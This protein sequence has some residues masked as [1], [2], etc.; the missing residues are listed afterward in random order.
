MNRSDWLN[1]VFP[2]IKRQPFYFP[3]L[4]QPEL[5]CSTQIFQSDE[6][7]LTYT[8][9]IPNAVTLKLN[10]ISVALWLN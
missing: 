2:F 6:F 1:P 8:N 10:H 3:F 5:Q 9:K 4:D 7:T